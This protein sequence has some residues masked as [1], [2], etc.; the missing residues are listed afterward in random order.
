MPKK[1]D[2]GKLVRARA[3]KLIGTVPGARVIPDKRHKPEKHKL[4]DMRQGARNEA[5][6]DA[7]R[8]A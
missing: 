4:N 8:A 1:L 6:A 7:I 5:P 3:R 2:A